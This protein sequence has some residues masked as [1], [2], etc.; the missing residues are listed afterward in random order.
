MTPSGARPYL[1][2]RAGQLA[3]IS[4]IKP[5]LLWVRWPPLHCGG[6]CLHTGCF[7]LAAPLHS[8][9]TPHEL[10]RENQV[11]EQMAGI[12]RNPEVRAIWL[13]ANR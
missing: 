8:E 9:G 11:A 13:T 1:E 6:M 10:G 4:G 3:P 2:E 7:S 5:Q 12:K